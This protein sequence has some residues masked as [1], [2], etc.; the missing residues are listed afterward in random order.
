MRDCSDNTLAGEEINM[1]NNLMENKK[2]VVTFWEAFSRSDIEGAI[3]LLTD[4]VSWWVSGKTN[5]SG[6]Y[7]KAGLRELFTSVVGGTKSGIRIIPKL[8]T[9]EA[10]RVAMEATSEGE[11]MDGR[12]YQNEYHFLHVVREGKLAEVR[13]YMDPEHVRDVFDA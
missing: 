9:A 2:V 11:T 8:M 12:F 1:T 13:E 7:D 6:T 4:D 3:D 5:I 10:N